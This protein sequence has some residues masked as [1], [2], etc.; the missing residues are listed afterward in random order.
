VHRRGRWRGSRQQFAH[1]RKLAGA[2]ER[3]RRRSFPH[4]KGESQRIRANLATWR[5]IRPVSGKVEVVRGRGRNIPREAPRLPTY[6][7]PVTLERLWAR[8]AGWNGVQFLP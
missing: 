6:P 7:P 1:S 4:R 3:V 2:Q 5:N 8:A